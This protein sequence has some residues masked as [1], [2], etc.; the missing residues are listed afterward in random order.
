MAGVRF[1]GRFGLR[2]L[3]ALLG[4]VPTLLERRRV[5][6]GASPGLLERRSARQPAPRANASHSD[7]WFAY[8]SV[9][10]GH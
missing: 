10:G 7:L 6:P 9:C 8:P 4:R 1:L 2:P 3:T 5:T